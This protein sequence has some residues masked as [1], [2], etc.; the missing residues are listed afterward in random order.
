MAGDFNIGFN[1]SF[2]EVQQLSGSGEY[3]FE[4]VIK[5]LG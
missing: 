3:N 2:T 5:F 1:V 4:P